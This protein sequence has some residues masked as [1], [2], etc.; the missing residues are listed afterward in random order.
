MLAD[1][2]LFLVNYLLDQVVVRGRHEIQVGGVRIFDFQVFYCR[3]GYVVELCQFGR[4]DYDLLLSCLG[5]SG[6]AW[7]GCCFGPG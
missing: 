1:E 6:G 3:C 7:L 5:L 2:V 4:S